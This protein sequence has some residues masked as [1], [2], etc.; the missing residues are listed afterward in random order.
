[1]YEKIIVIMTCALIFGSGYN[2]GHTLVVQE[3]AGVLEEA[4]NNTMRVLEEVATALDENERARI[5]YIQTAELGFSR[6]KDGDM[7]CLTNDQYIKLIM[8]LSGNRGCR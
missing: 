3:F 4:H 2:I 7:W 8:Q 1:M 6:C 5:K